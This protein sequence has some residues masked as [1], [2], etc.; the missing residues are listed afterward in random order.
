MTV[1]FTAIAIQGLFN[2]GKSQAAKK[3]TTAIDTTF[4]KLKLSGSSC[5]LI[6]INMCLAKLKNKI[7]TK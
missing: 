6:L 5:H 1:E 2:W 7:T 4:N 3:A